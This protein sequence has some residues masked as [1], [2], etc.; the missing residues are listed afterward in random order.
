MSRFIIYQ[1]E[2]D[3][4]GDV[5]E[6]ESYCDEKDIDF[7]LVRFDG[8]NYFYEYGYF[9]IS[10]KR[11]HLIGKMFIDNREYLIFSKSNLLIKLKPKLNPQISSDKDIF[12]NNHHYLV[13]PSS[14]IKGTYKMNNYYDIII[15]P[16]QGEEDSICTFVLQEIKYNYDDYADLLNFKFPKELSKIIV[17]YFPNSSQDYGYNYFGY[18]FI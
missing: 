13:W 17:Q 1:E 18:S 12:I 6:H 8:Y 3:E 14:S 16:T 2:E 11:Q 10:L 9:E 15:T 7:D 5:S 4:D